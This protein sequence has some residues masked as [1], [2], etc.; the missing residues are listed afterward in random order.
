M[1]FHA[2]MLMRFIMALSWSRGPSS[3][4][5]DAPALTMASTLACHCTLC[6]GVT[7]D[8]RPDVNESNLDGLCHQLLADLLD[9]LGQQ[10]VNW[11]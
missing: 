11:R 2:V 9:T 10:K 4:N 8:S 6:N 1:F 7:A 3:T 5:L